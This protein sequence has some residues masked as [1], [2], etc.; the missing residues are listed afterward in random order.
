MFSMTEF[1]LFIFGCIGVTAIIVDGEIFRPLKEKLKEKVPKWIDD[2]WN[3]YQCT[4]FWVGIFFGFLLNCRYLESIGDFG[5]IFLLG[6]ASSATSYFYA[7]YLTYLE[8]NSMIPF[9]DYSSE[10]NQNNGG[11]N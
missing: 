1:L 5:H 10:E 3:C 7:L 2:L 11:N 8:A 9:N 6:G 4:G